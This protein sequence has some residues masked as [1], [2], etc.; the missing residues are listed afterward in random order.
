MRKRPARK[1][2]VWRCPKCGHKIVTSECVGCK[3]EAKQ[4]NNLAAN[5]I[6][7]SQQ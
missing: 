5:L 1:V 6:R 7:K 2:R 3:V 4:E